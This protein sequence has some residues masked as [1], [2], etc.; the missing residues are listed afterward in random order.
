M[1]V[2]VLTKQFP[3]SQ[4]KWA[5]HSA[6]QTLRVLATM[7]DV[8]VFYPEVVYPKLLAP[9]GGRKTPL[10]RD[11][12]PGGVDVTYLPFTALPLVSRRLNGPVITRLMLPHIRAYKPDVILSY[13][14]YPDGYAAVKVGKKLGIP[15]VVTAVGSDLNR[16]PRFC[17]GPTQKTLREAA[18]VSTVSHDMCN[19]ARRLGAP[20]ERSRAKLNGCD[21]SV[22]Y[23]RDRAEARRSLGI[24][25]EGQAIV[26]VGRIDLRKGLIELI[27]SV[28]ALRADHPGLRCYI[29]GDGPDRPQLTEAIARH[30]AQE[31]IS[32]LPSCGTAEV[33]VWMAAA[34]LVTLP[35]YSEGCPNVVIEAL[36]SG[37]P[38]VA[39]DVGGIPELMDDTCGRMVPARDVPALTAALR[40]VLDQTWNAEEI[41]ARHGRSWQDV[42]NELYEALEFVIKENRR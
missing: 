4:Q 1:R 11:F 32:L 10:D 13:F 33:A 39:S 8:H 20:V 9:R 27:D 37:R 34:D 41:A 42:A 17:E 26:Y 16:I 2:A 3:T 36:A 22:F 18:W 25:A 19:T 23:P 15:A 28:A 6:Y 30:N 7:A 21:T 35:S 12:R 14:I 5:A 40:E 31:T 24:A 29:V 38:V